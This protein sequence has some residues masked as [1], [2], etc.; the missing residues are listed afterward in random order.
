MKEN[1]LVSAIVR[2][3][4]PRVHS[5]SMTLGA[6]SMNGT[7]DRY[8]DGAARDLWVEFKQLDAMPRS[9][10]AGG[11]T[12]ARVRK[13]GCYTSQQYDWMLRRHNNGGNVWGMIG[14]PNKLVVI[15][16]LPTQ[17]E[18]GSL[19]SE[20]VSRDFAAALILD[21]CLGTN[22]ARTATDCDNSRNRRAAS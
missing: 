11:I 9:G 1:N 14:L 19:V 5:Q 21:F 10:L 4:E 8:F 12:P 3:T 18:N 13:K 6:V 22:N 20:A 7:P 2:R 16:K 17:W 15:Q